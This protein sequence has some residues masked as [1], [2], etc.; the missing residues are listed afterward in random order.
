MDLKSSEKLLELNENQ[1]IIK[2]ANNTPL[3]DMVCIV[4][5]KK[6]YFVDKNTSSIQ[7]SEGFYVIARHDKDVISCNH[8]KTLPE[9]SESFTKI[10]TML[11]A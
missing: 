2:S 1:V 11:R 6:M 7:V 4:F 5:V 8:Y 3:N 10:L 9:A